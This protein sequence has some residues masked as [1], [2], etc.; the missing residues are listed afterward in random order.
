MIVLATTAPPFISAEW[1]YLFAVNPLLGLL[2]GL[3]VAWLLRRPRLRLVCSFMLANYLSA[4][5]ARSAL[6]P[7]ARLWMR[8]EMPWV[9]PLWG[10]WLLAPVGAALFVLTVAVEWSFATWGIRTERPKWWRTLLAT[11]LAQIVTLPV[12]LALLAGGSD[13]S[14]VTATTRDQA[15]RLAL[16]AAAEVYYISLDEAAV[17]RANFASSQEVTI[18]ALPSGDAD[19]NNSRL[20]LCPGDRPGTFDLALDPG[21]GGSWSSAAVPPLAT[22]IHRDSRPNDGQ[23]LKGVQ[24]LSAEQG[25]TVEVGERASDGLH[26]SSL[27][28]QHIYAME[29]PFARWYPATVTVLPNDLL[30]FDMAGH[31]WLLEPKSGR[32]DL[33]AK[34]QSPVVRLPSRPVEAPGVQRKPQST[35]LRL[36]NPRSQAAVG[37]RSG[38]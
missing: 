32:I 9:E 11:T 7:P 19:S 22:G 28:G 29:T 8:P 30:L 15:L 10:F 34:G 3:L 1:F 4:I 26:I 24:Y 36:F 12:I 35:P 6:L 2:E 21:H 27:A 25:T 33:L 17:K 13:A 31:I 16:P 5:L 37:R 18:A 14:F 38:L 23:C 20:L